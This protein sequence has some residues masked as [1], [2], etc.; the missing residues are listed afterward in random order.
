[1]KKLLFAGL[2]FLVCAGTLE[3][4]HS[5]GPLP[6][7]AP[8]VSPPISKVPSTP[9]VQVQAQPTKTT[10][11]G[12][13]S[14]QPSCN[15][16]F[17]VYSVYQFHGQTRYT[18]GLRRDFVEAATCP[19]G[20]G[21]P[22]WLNFDLY[23]CRTPGAIRECFDAT[24]RQPIEPYTQAFYDCINRNSAPIPENACPSPLYTLTNP[25]GAVSAVAAYSCSLNDGIPHDRSGLPHL[26]NQCNY[27]DSGG[28]YDP[29]EGS[30]LLLQSCQ[31]R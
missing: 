20:W 11:G 5:A 21:N 22:V 24:Y 26:C 23:S 29:N 17:A 19:K 13:C 1:M 15:G 6:P 3:T 16:E 9:Q 31:P 4:A 7:S 8:T 14:A 27:M 30:N 10:D 18:C 25:G 2:M 12:G 28:T